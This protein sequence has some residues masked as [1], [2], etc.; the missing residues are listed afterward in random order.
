MTG[1][2]PRALE[3][4]AALRRYAAAL[5]AYRAQRWRDALRLF[6]EVLAVWPGD[7]PARVMI[8]RCRAFVERA[9]RRRVAGGWWGDT[10]PPRQREP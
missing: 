7:G 4:V 9:V 1:G 2:D 6:E 3:E 10:R 8:A 5:E